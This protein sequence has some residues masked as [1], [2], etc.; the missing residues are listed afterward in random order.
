MVITGREGVGERFWWLFLLEQS[1]AVHIAESD[2][3]GL[4]LDACW[5]ILDSDVYYI[6][7]RIRQ[8]SLPALRRGGGRCAHW[9]YAMLLSCT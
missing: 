8:A 6:G 3:V 2:R 1:E 9:R 5:E 7:V 4:S